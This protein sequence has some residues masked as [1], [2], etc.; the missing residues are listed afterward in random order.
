MDFWKEHVDSKNGLSTVS[1][2]NE[3]HVIGGSPQ[4]GGYGSSV[5]RYF[6]LAAVMAEDKIDIL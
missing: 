2:G 5:K 6:M 3:I 4:P 1:F